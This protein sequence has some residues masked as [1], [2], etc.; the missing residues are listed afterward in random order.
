MTPNPENTERG[1]V[2]P[3]AKNLP[4]FAFPGNLVFDIIGYHVPVPADMVLLAWLRGGRA[5]VE[6]NILELVFYHLLLS[7][8]QLELCS[9]PV[10]GFD[11]MKHQCAFGMKK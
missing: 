6:E 8:A 10:K 5:E 1:I 3:S 9:A 7:S 4:A 2:E 11:S